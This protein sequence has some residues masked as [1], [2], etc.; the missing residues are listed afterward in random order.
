MQTQ[1]RD[2]TRKLQSGALTFQARST[3]FF[4]A[5][6][7][8]DGNLQTKDTVSNLESE[9]QELYAVGGRYFLVALLPKKIPYFTDVSRRLDPAIAKIPGDLKVALPDAHIKISHWGDYFDRVIANPARYGLTNIKEKCAGRALFGEDPTP[10][11]TPD[12]YYYFHEG[13]PSTAVH[14]VVG[15]ELAN[16]IKTS[17]F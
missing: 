11:A 3:L 16:E 8:N 1:V 9:I 5:G 10:C 6:G 14:K 2:F 7:L 17:P 12:A 13:H 15:R 4:L